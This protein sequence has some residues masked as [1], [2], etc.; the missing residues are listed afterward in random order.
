MAAPSGL[1]S[2]ETLPGWSRRGAAEAPRRSPCKRPAAAA[3]AAAEAAPG[4][5]G[6]VRT[7]DDVAAYFQQG[8]A[9]EF[10]YCVRADDAAEA[11]AASHSV[12]W[13]AAAAEFFLTVRIAQ[14]LIV[15]LAP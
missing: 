10:F 6:W 4:D 3:S 5:A 14:L 9:I 12:S 2:V 15:P 7:D 1:F 11:Q 8:G 13:E